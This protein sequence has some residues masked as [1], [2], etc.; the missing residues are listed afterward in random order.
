M[1]ILRYLL[2]IAVLGVLVSACGKKL[3]ES[4][5]ILTTV[6]N[7][8]AEGGTEDVSIM[9]NTNWSVSSDQGWLHFSP[10][11]GSGSADYQTLKITVDKNEGEETR[12]AM[13]TVSGGSLSKLIQVTQAAS[14]RFTIADFKA[15]K[16]DKTTWYKLTGEI[17]S[18]PESH[19]GNFYMADETGFVYVYGLCEK[20]VDANDQSFSKLGLKAGDVVTM[21]TLRSEYN[22]IIEAGGTTP[23]YFVSK[24]AGEYKM[25][26]KVASTKVGWMEMPATSAT[27]GQDLLIH[28]FPD[29]KR[30]YS[31]YWNYQKFV[32]TWVAYPLHS[33][34]I[35]T[36]GR[37]IDGAFPMDPLLTQSQ[38][39]YL[40]SGFKTGNVTGRSFD[41]GHQIP[42]ADRQDWRVNVESFFSTNMT[43]QDNGLNGQAWASLE[44]KVRAWAK[45]STTDTLYVVTGC[46][47]KAELE[48]QYALD[49]DSK[50]IAI[51][52]GYYKALLRLSKDKQYIAVGFYYDNVPNTD[53]NVKNQAM[54]IDDL[55]TKVGVDFFINLPDDV[56]KSVEAQNPKETKLWWWNN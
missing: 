40:P 29:G 3:P 14:P 30:S 37:S 17:I 53:T 1:K 10:S 32:S 35:G 4:L 47:T 50:K 52:T 25:G 43:P 36:G 7:L 56:E 2:I 23:A 28:R 13:V 24:E 45:N 6:V 26:K 41:R 38:Q 5:N 54:S 12:Q 27:D 48:D 22:G 8:P 42:S 31:A 55:E 15:K 16:A 20:K 44:N 39:P 49:G 51:P 21:M 34:N 33:G 46:T 18:L 11:G 19:Y 9:T